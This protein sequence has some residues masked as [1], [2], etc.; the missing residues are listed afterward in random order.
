[1]RRGVSVFSDLSKLETSSFF[2]ENVI[3]D[4]IDLKTNN[5]FGLFDINYSLNFSYLCILCLY[6][7]GFIFIACSSS[8][9]LDE[10][11]RGCCKQIQ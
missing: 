9:S 5:I 6:R 2:R 4:N 3:E 1:M 10:R 11:Y 7:N 8:K